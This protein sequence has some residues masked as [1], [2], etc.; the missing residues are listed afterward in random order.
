[1]VAPTRERILEAL[2][3]E[4]ARTGTL[5]QYGHIR[6][7]GHRIR[8]TQTTEG[9][10]VFTPEPSLGEDVDP[11]EIILREDRFWATLIVLSDHPMSAQE[12]REEVQGR[13]CR[14]LPD[15]LSRHLEWAVAQKRG[16]LTKTVRS[17]PWYRRREDIVTISIYTSPYATPLSAW[18]FSLEVGL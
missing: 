14:D 15:S 5:V 16:V 9:K 10:W 11:M 3:S 2:L 12:I 18:D 4:A 17:G 13:L 8:V 6:V 1:M 7:D